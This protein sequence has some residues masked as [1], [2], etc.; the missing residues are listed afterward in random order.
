NRAGAGGGVGAEFVAH[1]APDGYTL[2]V[3]SNGPLTIN[4]LINANIS[5]DALSAFAPVA[6][7]SYVPHVL[8]VSNKLSVK[9]VADLVALAKARPVNLATSGIGS[10]THMT[11][12]RFK[13][14]IG[15][16]IAHVPY[17]SGGSLLPD[18]ISG[19]VDGAMTEL[20]TAAELHKG[21]QALILAVAGAA[22][23]KLAPDIP[24]FEEESVKGFVARS[25]IGILAPAKTPPEHLA[26][27]Q[28]AIAAGLGAGSEAAAKLVATGSELAT[29][30]QMT[31]AGFA[32][33]I[34][35]DFADMQAA[36][37]LAGLGK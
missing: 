21:G 1:A 7:V 24:T 2:L 29:P 17:K 31:P 19:N 11:L 35:R 20:S 10:A 9:S 30:E 12:E 37:K 18:V 26:K 15:A 28:A 25:F 23:S 33:Y 16:P 22:R 32:E 13:Q 5:Y 3:G 14:A 36:A 27:L 4:P 8:I 6:M 34:K